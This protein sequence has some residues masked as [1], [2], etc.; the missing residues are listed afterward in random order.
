MKI[1]GFD[2]LEK[3]GEGPTGTLWK[4]YQSS[5]DR[6]VA[7]KLLR[8]SS[9]SACGDVQ[10]LLVRTRTA[11]KIKHPSILQLY[12][13][14]Q[15]D[16]VYYFVMELVDGMSLEQMLQQKGTLPTGKALKITKDIIFGLEAAWE[17]SK[18]PHL[19][20]KP[21]N[22]M[23]EK[24]GAAK[25]TDLGMPSRTSHFSLS[26][27]IQTG[28]IETPV[29]YISP[30]QAR[31][32]THIDFRSDVYSLG[33]ILYRMV[34]GKI[35]FAEKEPNKIIDA[36]INDYLPYPR[37]ID[38]TLRHGICQLITRMMMKDPANRYESWRELSRDVNRLIGGAALLQ[39]RV[40][41]G[42]STV[43]YPDS[44]A[45]ENTERLRAVA[46]KGVPL[47][48]R[49]VAWLLLPVWWTILGIMLLKPIRHYPRPS[50][51]QPKS[52]AGIAPS[53]KPAPT[54]SEH[55][56]Q[57][58][59]KPESA[60]Q[61][62]IKKEEKPSIIETSGE[63][64][65]QT[66]AEEETTT[67]TTPKEVTAAEEK[68]VET[69]TQLPAETETPASGIDFREK[70]ENLK[71]KVAD[72]CMEEK[73]DK[74]LESISAELTATQDAGYR[75]ELENLRRFVISVAGINKQIA[76]N[77]ANSAGQTITIRFRNSNMP[78]KIRAVIG[79]KIDA[80]V[81]SNVKG[82][83]VESPVSFSVEELSVAERLKW[84]GPVDSPVKHAMKCILN[85]RLKDYRTASDF[86]ANAGPLADALCKHLAF[87]T[88]VY[89][90]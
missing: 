49:T 76:N 19:N 29:N 75:N 78:L 69:T 25:L 40:S 79:T 12:D 61:P 23:I 55:I 5:L 42:N 2:I 32:L 3:I 70:L 36:H 17:F 84:L 53:T 90:P 60:S 39:K 1:Q 11:A 33:A 35:P 87:K 57:P 51:P 22:I 65:I 81:V 54:K 24:S 27:Q 63:T 7:L 9:L 58:T 72:S 83:H 56:T 45:Q 68:L 85:A 30:E 89:G 21:Q 26:Q 14:A 64:E 50:Q 62:V 31:C 16:D 77:L 52:S 37:E 88:A 13:M 59:P 46:E 80:L 66:A 41:A 20:L 34:T 44:S 82:A 8:M 71:M 10:E 18:L 47:A 67:Q 74:A 38:P 15:Q 48:F 86:A 73:F 28:H 6:V 43:Q 4:A